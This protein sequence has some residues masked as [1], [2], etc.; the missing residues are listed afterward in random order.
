[1]RPHSIPCGA[2]EPLLEHCILR[3]LEPVEAPGRARVCAAAGVEPWHGC[4]LTASGDGPAALRDFLAQH[5]VTACP[6]LPGAGRR[7]RVR[8]PRVGASGT[9][10][11]D[12]RLPMKRRPVSA[13]RR[14]VRTTNPSPIATVD[15]NLASPSSQALGLPGPEREVAAPHQCA[16]VLRSWRSSWPE[17]HGLVALT[18]S[19][20]RF[21]STG[22]LSLT[23]WDRHLHTAG[24]PLPLLLYYDGKAPP[25]HPHT[26]C[27]IDLLVRQPWLAGWSRGSAAMLN[28]R[29]GHSNPQC[30]TLA[31]PD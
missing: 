12:G 15:T 26:S 16:H 20:E 3:D 19:S 22:N 2:T 6:E 9:R 24:L 25:V 23:L 21:L 11:D 28:A 18:S 17:S 30:S 8:R 10:H 1:M 14:R 31:K 27:T 7:R 5:N 4:R 13:E 29:D